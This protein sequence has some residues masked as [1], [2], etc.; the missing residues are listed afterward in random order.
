[1]ATGVD[2][3]ISTN[4]TSSKNARYISFWV[5]AKFGV[6]CLVRRIDLAHPHGSVSPPACCHYPLVLGQSPTW[7]CWSSSTKTLASLRN[8][9]DGA[10]SLSLSLSLSPLPS[11]HPHPYPNNSHI[12]LWFGEKLLSLT[13]QRGR[14]FGLYPHS[15]SPT[16]DLVD[17][18]AP[19]IFE[20]HQVLQNDLPWATFTYSY[21]CTSWATRTQLLH[22]VTSDLVMSSRLTC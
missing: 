17:W 3:E 2:P 22:T 7:Q 19:Q 4:E 15:R 11:I 9:V 18:C 12:P 14:A 5:I 16:Y 13:R 8:S 10:A 20:F 21:L 1:M 6:H